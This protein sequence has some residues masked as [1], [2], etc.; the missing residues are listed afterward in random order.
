[1]DE[2]ELLR[3]LHEVLH[4]DLEALELVADLVELLAR[5]RAERASAA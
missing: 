5:R 4:D 1:M 2:S 3:R